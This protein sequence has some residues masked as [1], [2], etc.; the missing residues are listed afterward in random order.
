MLTL[1]AGL[2]AGCLARLLR[3]D[4]VSVFLRTRVVVLL[5]DDTGA[6]VGVRAQSPDGPVEHRGATTCGGGYNSGMALSRGLTMAT[7]WPPVS[8]AATAR[9]HPPS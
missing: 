5:R 2:V 6:V 8:A 9:R 1:G 4:R 7:S 3:E